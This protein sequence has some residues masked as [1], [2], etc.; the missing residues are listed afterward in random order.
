MSLSWRKS[1]SAIDDRM[2][3][4]VV[5]SELSVNDDARGFSCCSTRIL[6]FGV[7][8]FIKVSLSPMICHLC[9]LEDFG[10]AIV[11]HSTL[12]TQDEES[13]LPRQTS[14]TIQPNTIPFRVHQP[15]E[16]ARANS[17]SCG[18]T[19]I[20]QVTLG[21]GKWLNKMRLLYGSSGVHGCRLG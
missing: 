18:R 17:C 5:T 6:G 8:V 19:E 14:H 13:S 15:L 9:T 2:P 4:V 7:I 21:E 10:A 1:T 16:H 11:Y 3:N 20:R 12:G